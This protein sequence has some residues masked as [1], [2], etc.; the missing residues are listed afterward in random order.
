VARLLVAS[1]AAAVACG[2]AYCFA[3]TLG[4]S[5]TGLGAG[6]EVVAS[7][8][9]G[10]RFAYTTS[11]SPTVS[12]HVVDGIEVSDIPAGCLGE[13]LSATFY[14]R[15]GSPVGAPVGATLTASGTTQSIAVAP[16]SDAI[17]ASRISGVSVV[18]S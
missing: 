7:C 3:A 1:L 12:G 9:D 15:N 13:N 6:S 17:D 16:R 4:F 2:G 18:L 14:D 10:M 8:G 11:F 5:A